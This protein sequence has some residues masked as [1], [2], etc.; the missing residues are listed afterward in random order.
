MT[1]PVKYQFMP[2]LSP[3]E[4]ADLETSIRKHGVMVPILRDTNEV[5]I[6]GHHRLRIAQSLGIECPAETLATLDETALRTLVFELNLH[7]RHLTREQRRTLVAES[8]KA[9][10]QLSNREHAQRAGI[11]HKTAESVRGSLAAAGEIPHLREIH[12]RDGKT[13][14]RW[15]QDPARDPHKP[16]YEA[17]VRAPVCAPVVQREEKLNAIAGWEQATRELIAELS[18][19]EAEVMFRAFD[20]LEAELA[21]RAGVSA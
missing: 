4:Y 8:I 1:T 18:H 15:P 2:P 3:E 7:R 21:Q 20:R 11:D 17:Y 9:D 14:T 6:D 19:D 12:G 10:P 13:Y 16:M 5:V